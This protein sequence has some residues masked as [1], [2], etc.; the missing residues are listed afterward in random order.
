MSVLPEATFMSLLS[1]QRSLLMWCGIV[2]AVICGV[3]VGQPGSALATSSHFPPPCANNTTNLEDPATAD[4][5][6]ANSWVAQ[7]TV[8]Q[9]TQVTV[10]TGAYD[11]PK[12]GATLTDPA[13]HPVAANVMVLGSDFTQA[14]GAVPPWSLSSA[15]TGNTPPIAPD[16]VQGGKKSTLY[17]YTGSW[18]APRLDPLGPSSAI[19]YL[20]VTFTFADGTQVQFFTNMLVVARPSDV[21]T[22]HS[23]WYDTSGMAGLPSQNTDNF[24]Y[25]IFAAGSRVHLESHYFF[26]ANPAGTSAGGGASTSSLNSVFLSSRLAAGQQ[27]IFV[28]APAG[29]QQAPPIGAPIVLPYLAPGQVRV[30]AT[31]PYSSY[32]S[33][34]SALDLPQTGTITVNQGTMPGAPAWTQYVVTVDEPFSVVRSGGKK[35]DAQVGSYIVDNGF[36]GP[37]AD[38]QGSQGDNLGEGRYYAFYSNPGQPLPTQPDATHLRFTWSPPDPSTWDS[39]TTSVSYILTVLDATAAQGGALVEHT[40]RTGAL[41]QDVPG[42]AGD[43]FLIVPGHEY[44]ASVQA[45]FT[46]ADSSRI[47]SSSIDG[48]PITARTSGGPPPTDTAIV[49]PIATATPPATAT[50]TPLPTATDTPLPTQTPTP[51]DTPTDTPTPRPGLAALRIDPDPGCYAWVFLKHADDSSATDAHMATTWGSPNP[52]H[53]LWPAGR[54]LHLTPALDGNPQ[55]VVL[56]LADPNNG[57]VAYLNP[58]TID[59]GTYTLSTIGCSPLP[60]ATP[61]PYATSPTYH[62]EIDPTASALVHID[63][64]PS[65]LSSAAP[66]GYQVCDIR[67]ILQHGGVVGLRFTVQ[68]RFIFDALG[69]TPTNTPTATPSPQP[70]PMTVLIYPDLPGSPVDRSGTAYQ[71]YVNGQPVHQ[72]GVPGDGPFV[73]CPPD[74]APSPLI[75]VP[76]GQA[77]GYYAT[78]AGT[79]HSDPAPTATPHTVIVYVTPT[80]GPTQTPTPLPPTLTP[81]PSPTWP[82]PS[83]MPTP[84]PAPTSNPFHPCPPDCAAAPPPAAWLTPAPHGTPATGSL[85]MPVMQTAVAASMPGAIITPHPHAS[86][87]QCQD[88]GGGAPT[89]LACYEV[90]I[91][92]PVTQTQV[93]TYSLVLKQEVPQP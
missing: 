26:S 69:P 79:C 17:E 4:A 60:A 18:T 3:L 54:P 7:H 50:D 39:A 2:L 86:D 21:H 88:T 83:M 40:Y 70:V 85:V 49:P 78:G 72:D 53:F 93:L 29:A 16:C 92:L 90:L 35:A 15:N 11:Q 1:R 64:L 42:S 20:A 34:T 76:D 28:N 52:C 84:L 61:A 9:G 6:S 32:D 38:G 57:A 5:Y 33:D 87:A 73:V 48:P 25:N 81:G 19:F 91:T 10:Y 74:P 36:S 14:K 46:F 31:F 22:M 44:A 62:A 27:P 51:L 89:L 71:R 63:W 67:D 59:P 30:S 13:Q 65:S 8:V 58:T 12:A 47:T 68:R 77:T 56:T 37:V 80:P 41:T 66:P 82:T 24:A 23:L 75:L 45:I 55:R 43:P